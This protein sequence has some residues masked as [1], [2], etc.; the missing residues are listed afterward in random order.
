MEKNFAL[1]C[2]LFLLSSLASPQAPSAKQ[3]PLVLTHVTVIDT[4][5]ASAQPDVTIVIRGDRIVGMGKS[6]KIRVPAGR[7]VPS[8][9]RTKPHL[10][11]RDP[12]S[13][14]AFSYRV[15]ETKDVA[16]LEKAVNDAD[17]EGYEPVGYVGHVHMLVPDFYLVLEKPI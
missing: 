9:M 4:T 13:K 11:E 6:G 10:L 5:G 1:L 8:A 16:G 2:L 15:L 12:N 7:V 14:Q 17:R 3:R